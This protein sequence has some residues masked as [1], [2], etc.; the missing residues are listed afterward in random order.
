MSDRKVGPNVIVT[1]L[2]SE[3]LNPVTGEVMR[4]KV[5]RL[6]EPKK[7]KPRQTMKPDR[8]TAGY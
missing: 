4:P 8:Y 6:P 7:I 5:V 1:E 2:K 3:W